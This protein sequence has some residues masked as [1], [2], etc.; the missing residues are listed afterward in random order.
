[1]AVKGSLISIQNQGTVRHSLRNSSDLPQV[2]TAKPASQLV[3]PG[4]N[5]EY[6]LQHQSS[7]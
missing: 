4:V 7:Y 6:E 1:M 5:T 3:R 2:F